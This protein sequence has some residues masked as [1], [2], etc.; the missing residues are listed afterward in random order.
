[1]NRRSYKIQDYRTKM[2]EMRQSETPSNMEIEEES[3]IQELSCVDPYS[4]MIPR[5]A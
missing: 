4:E 2:N 3:E 5:S 1:M